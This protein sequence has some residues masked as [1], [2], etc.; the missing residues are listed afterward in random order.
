MSRRRCLREWLAN[1]VSS[2]GSVHLSYSNTLDYSE[3]KRYKGSKYMHI[4]NSK[5]LTI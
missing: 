1:E 5:I 3:F 4:P 2:R